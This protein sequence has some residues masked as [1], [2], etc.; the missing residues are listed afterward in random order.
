MSDRDDGNR[1]IPD[2]DVTLWG[3]D[4]GQVERCLEDLVGRLEQ[5]L[6]QLDA[7]DVLH[8][9][10]CDAHVEIDQLRFSTEARI[11]DET[12]WGGRLSEIMAAAE[13]LRARAEQEALQGQPAE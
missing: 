10:L 6:V 12:S 8:S 13:E 3:Y 11:E 4:R 1:Y 2:F 9:Q 7:V 5:A